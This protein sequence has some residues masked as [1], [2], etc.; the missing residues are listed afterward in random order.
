MFVLCGW[1]TKYDNSKLEMFQLNILAEENQDAKVRG[2]PEDEP[3]LQFGEV[4]AANS[5]SGVII[6]SWKTF[7]TDSHTNWYWLEVWIISGRCERILLTM[8]RG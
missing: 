2:G 7:K 4:W 6:P 8:S 5:G 3:L 1:T